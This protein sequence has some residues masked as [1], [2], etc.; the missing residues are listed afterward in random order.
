MVPQN[1]QETHKERVALRKD[2]DKCTN[3]N[4]GKL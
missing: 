2:L 1:I 3:V 4:N